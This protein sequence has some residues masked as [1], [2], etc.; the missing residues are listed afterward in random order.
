MNDLSSF[1]ELVEEGGRILGLDRTVVERI[2]R[3]D[4]VLEVPLLFRR[5]N[6][7][8]GSAVGFRVQ[9]SNVLGPYKGGIRFHPEVDESEVRALAAWMS[10]K[11]ALMNIPFGGGKGGVRI[12][13]KVLS[14]RELEA[15]SRS[16]VRAL[17]PHLGPDKDVPAPDV[18]TNEMVMG[19]MLEEY[20]DIYG[21][22]QG[23]IT[24]KPLSMGGIVGRDRA[25]GRGAV[26]VLC[27]FIE[28]E[29]MEGRNVVIHGFGNAGRTVAELLYEKGFC[30]VGI[31]DSK[32]GLY[33]GKG[34]DVAA[35]GKWKDEKGSLVGYP[36]TELLDPSLLL[37][38][39]CDILV[40]ASLGG[41]I[42]KENM[43]GIRA[44]V[45]LEVAN[46]PLSQTAYRYLKEKVIILP[47]VLANAGG[48]T[49]SYF[50]WLQNI[51]G[52]GWEKDEVDR[53]LERVMK[54]AVQSVQELRKQH[55]VDYKTAAYLVGLQRISDS[56]KSSV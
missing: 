1:S 43:E 22:S 10:V 17:H 31:A 7:S 56:I 18:Y 39:E 33:D 51:E 5:D 53:R 8:L 29:G 30:V 2:I 11:C 46:G 55:G 41:V 24:G 25:T 27:S 12:N 15:L 44:R 47:D 48:V 40:P 16:Y 14:E 13:P 52:S 45:I 28:L 23:M 34:L 38:K 20:E 37:L 36:A 9:H 4:R 6:G 35:V 21:K 54:E 32:Q 42:T 49:V 26:I 50:E 3:P 19:W